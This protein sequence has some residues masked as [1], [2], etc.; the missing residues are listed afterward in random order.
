MSHED[1]A[2]GDA[3]ATV[4]VLDQAD[5]AELAADPYL[6]VPVTELPPAVQP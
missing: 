6:K 3:A 5:L 2:E 4:P 1:A